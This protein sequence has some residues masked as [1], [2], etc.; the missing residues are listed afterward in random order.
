MRCLF[1]RNYDSLFGV[2][3][4]SFISFIIETISTESA[5]LS[6]SKVSTSGIKP[7]IFITFLDT[8]LGECVNKQV[9]GWLKY[10]KIM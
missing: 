9:K 8:M 7:L 3:S 6:L 5:Q 1:Y 10:H 2:Y 4:N